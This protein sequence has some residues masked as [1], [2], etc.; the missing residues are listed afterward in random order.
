[1]H[2]TVAPGIEV[3]MTIRQST[4]VDGLLENKVAN[5][6]EGSDTEEALDLGHA[7]CA[8]GRTGRS[9]GG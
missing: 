4:E 9:R 1:M 6:T 3:K 5:G 7:L 8:A 2:T